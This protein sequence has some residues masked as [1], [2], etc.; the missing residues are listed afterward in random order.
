MVMNLL[1]GLGLIL[2]MVI[3]SGAA[4]EIF[5][6]LAHEVRV[7]RLILATMLV[8]FSTSLPELFVGLAAAVRSQPEIALGNVMGAN[9]ANLSWII[10]GAVLVFGTIP[11]VGEY[12]KK[13]LWLTVAMA[14][15]PFLLISDGR[16]GRVDGLIL[17][18]LYFGYV[19]KLMSKGSAP[20]KHLKLLG[21]KMVV[22]R[23]KTKWDRELTLVKLLMALG[24]LGASSWMLINL[25]VSTSSFLEVSLFWIGLVVI[26][27]GTTLPELVLSLMASERR[28]VSLILGNILGSVVVNSTIV[29]GI[30][31]IISPI[32]YTNTLQ[33]GVVGVFL[34]I[35]LGL[36]WLF[37]K[38]K[39]KLERWEGA[40]L[41]GIYAMFFGLQLILA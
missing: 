23:A 35:T 30:V 2:V 1:F 5:E 41:V 13:E 4:V 28:E 6:K 7:N 40:V 14:M 32:T 10:G 3:A 29:L 16:L 33:K 37:T 21:R 15:A 38:S 22:H 8:G 17:V 34:M 26:S 25:A 20:L 12:L 27:I 9:L 19:Y 36:F 24:V 31:A 39:H 18:L 11:V